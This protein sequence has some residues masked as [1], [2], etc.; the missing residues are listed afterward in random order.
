MVFFDKFFGLQNNYHKISKMKVSLYLKLTCTVLLK[1]V[2]ET[3]EPS[4]STIE[5]SFGEGVG[6]MLVIGATLQ[7]QSCKL[8]LGGTRRK[9]CTSLWAQKEAQEN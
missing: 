8:S 3:V 2:H 6:D 4:T 9:R 1:T 5:V 7:M